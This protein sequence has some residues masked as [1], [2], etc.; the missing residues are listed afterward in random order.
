MSIVRKEDGWA[1]VSDIG[2]YLAK[3]SPFNLKNYGYLRLVT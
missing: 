2:L 3:Q 1:N